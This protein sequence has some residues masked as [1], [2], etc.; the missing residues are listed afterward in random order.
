[1]LLITLKIFPG[2][3][4]VLSLLIML[5]LGLALSHPQYSIYLW[6]VTHR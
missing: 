4:S 2:N 3:F 5:L 6:T 1:M